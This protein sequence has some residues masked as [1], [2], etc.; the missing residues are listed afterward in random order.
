MSADP[1]RPPVKLTATTELRG[2]L[3]A[4]DMTDFL[5]EVPPGAR[6]TVTVQTGDPRDP[7]EATSRSVRIT[8]TWDGPTKPASN[9]RSPR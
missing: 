2:E 9:L 1:S 3:T 7:G 8:A 6:L 5:R 4:G